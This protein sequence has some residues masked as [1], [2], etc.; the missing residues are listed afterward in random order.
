MIIG[1]VI[2]VDKDFWNFDDI[3][4]ENSTCDKQ[5]LGIFYGHWQI[6]LFKE[7][8]IITRNNKSTKKEWRIGNFKSH[9]SQNIMPSN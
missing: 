7:L 9:Y 4:L 1:A 2:C 6:N 3:N 5:G 8:E